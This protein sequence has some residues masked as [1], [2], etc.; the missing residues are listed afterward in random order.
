V[1]SELTAAEMRKMMQDVVLMGTA[2][3]AV[4][5][6]GYSAAGKTGTAQKIDPRTHT[7]SKTNFVASFVGFAPVNNPAITIAVVMDSPDHAFHFG[8]QASAPVFQDLAHQILVYLGVPHDEPMLSPGLKPIM[9]VADED[10]PAENV[11]DLDS[12]F[13]EV[14]NLPADDP[15]RAGPPA[16]TR[17]P[18]SKDD[19]ASQPLDQKPA[20]PPHSSPTVASVDLQSQP[21]PALQP[22]PALIAQATPPGKPPSLSSDRGSVIVASGARVAVPSFAGEPIRKVIEQA[23]GVGLGVQVLGT[24]IARGQAPAAGTMV[25]A[26]TEVVVRF[27]R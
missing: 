24:G 16:Q 6:N 5:L 11:D 1:V 13:A 21:Q 19:N 26:G 14:N 17:L 18:E 2:H 12:L 20:V 8:A 15:L 4:H 23:G 3:G 27:G 7:Y 22:A 9:Q 25:P 10:V